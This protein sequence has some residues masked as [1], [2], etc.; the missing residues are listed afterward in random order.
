MKLHNFSNHHHPSFPIIAVDA[1][2]AGQREGQQTGH[3]EKGD[4]VQPF[5]DEQVPEPARG[6]FRPAKHPHAHRK[7]GGHEQGRIDQHQVGGQFF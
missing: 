7:K 5:L 3:T 2:Y 1:I 4:V 6:D